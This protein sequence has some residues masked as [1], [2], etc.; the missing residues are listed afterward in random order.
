MLAHIAVCVS[1]GRLAMFSDNKTKVKLAKEAEDSAK[2][3]LRIDP[4]SDLAHHLMGRWNFEMAGTQKS[5]PLAVQL[6][7]EYCEAYTLV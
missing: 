7:F 6:V 3:A 2:E 5:C 4:N 1:K